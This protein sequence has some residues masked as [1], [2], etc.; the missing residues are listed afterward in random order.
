MRPQLG[1]RSEIGMF[2]RAINAL[3]DS[4]EITVECEEVVAAAV[5]LSGAA[6][7][8]F[9]DALIAVMNCDAGCRET[10]TFESRF[11][12]ASAARLIGR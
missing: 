2:A 8:D 3:L 1:R 12:K 7:L 11:A 9:I 6:N 4:M 5:N 10:W